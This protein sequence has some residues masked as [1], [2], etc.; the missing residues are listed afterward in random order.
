MNDIQLPMP[1]HLTGPARTLVA[2]LLGRMTGG[3]ATLLNEEIREA[4]ERYDVAVLANEV[5]MDL[6]LF[7]RYPS[8]ILT[9]EKP[10]R[11]VP[12]EEHAAFQA[13]GAP[14]GTYVPNMPEEWRT[15]WKA[16][17]CGQRTGW[18]RVEIRKSVQGIQVVIIV[19]KE[20][21]QISQNGT[22]AWSDQD[23]AALNQAVGEAR[24]AIAAYER[25]SR[26]MA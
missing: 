23:W 4:D 12:P 6:W 14:P 22:A 25:Q 3:R 26:E 16:K 7:D 5:G 10:P 1:G 2:A 20:R 18:L 15:A 11:A 8:K 19:E 24:E 9:W 13:D 21:I 17:L